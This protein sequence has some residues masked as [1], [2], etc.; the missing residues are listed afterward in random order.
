MDQ[1][2]LE[3]RR[4]VVSLRI[5]LEHGNGGKRRSQTYEKRVKNGTRAMKFEVKINLEFYEWSRKRSYARIGN[6]VNLRDL[7]LEL[8][9][10]KS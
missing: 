5:G 4:G 9:R 7:L 1:D 8:Q 10:V 3:I 2:A 6:S